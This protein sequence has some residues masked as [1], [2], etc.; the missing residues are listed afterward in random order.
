MTSTLYS[1]VILKL[2]EMFKMTNLLIKLNI[3]GHKFDSYFISC[4]IHDGVILDFIF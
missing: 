1:S 2:W 4:C 3:V